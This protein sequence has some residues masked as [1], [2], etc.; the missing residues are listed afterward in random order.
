[1]FAKCP[2]CNSTDYVIDDIIDVDEY[3]ETEEIKKSIA[4]C[5][6]CD[7]RFLINSFFKWERDE[8]IKEID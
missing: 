5:D 8:F 7:C 4:V 3:T 1:M 2:K 6:C